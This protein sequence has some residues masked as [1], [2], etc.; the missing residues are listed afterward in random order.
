MNNWVFHFFTQ[1]PIYFCI[2]TLT[3]F[4]II[5][6]TF[7]SLQYCSQRCVCQAVPCN[8]MWCDVLWCIVF[9]LVDFLVTDHIMYCIISF[10]RLSLSIQLFCH[11]PLPMTIFHHI[12]SV[13][14]LILCH[15]LIASLPPNPKH[16][17]F[18]EFQI[19][20]LITYFNFLLVGPFYI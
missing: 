4:I 17:Q 20:P 5:F 6:H 8:L 11:F 10:R 18:V 16:F 7:I 9:C 13:A 12:I 2:K 15:C 1:K 19:F 3:T 14:P